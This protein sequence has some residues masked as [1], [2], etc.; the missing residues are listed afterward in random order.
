MS[1]LIPGS[2]VLANAAAMISAGTLNYRV[3]LLSP[4][5]TVDDYG[6]QTTAWSTFAS[7]RANLI[8]QKGNRSTIGGEAWDAGQM[9]VI[10]RYRSG[11]NFRMRVRRLDTNEVYQITNVATDVKEGSITIQCVAMDLIEAPAPPVPPE[12]QSAE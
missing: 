2:A 12:T 6:Q 7:T 8:Q 1:V 9:T 3:E 4:T 10:I 11:V 5:V